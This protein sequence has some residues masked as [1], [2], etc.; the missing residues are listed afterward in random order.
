MS[1]E[2]SKLDKNK[3]K[4]IILKLYDYA[5]KMEQQEQKSVFECMDDYSAFK[6]DP[7]SVLAQIERVQRTKKSLPKK[8]QK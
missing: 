3:H 1:H 4:S 7:N 2:K 6:N 5:V 8:F